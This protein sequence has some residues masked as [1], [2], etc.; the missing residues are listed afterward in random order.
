MGGILRRLVPLIVVA[1]VIFGAYRWWVGRA[2]ANDGALD[3]S[4]TIEATEVSVSAEVSGR[5]KSVMAGE[6]D[7]VEAGQ[8][9]VQLDDVLIQAQRKQ[10]VASV[11]AALGAQAAAQAA[12]TAAQAQ[13]DQLKAG[14]RPQ[15]IACRAAGR[16]RRTGTGDDG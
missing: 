13:L 1:G 9:L 4:G 11:N 14:A 8:A 10:S 6:G 7:H 15:E 12:Q 16:A 5:V 2:V 3:A